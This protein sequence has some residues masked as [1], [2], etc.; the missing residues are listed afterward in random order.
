[1]TDL[2][3][4]I[5]TGGASSRMGTDKARLRLGG[6]SFVE[7]IAAA[8]SSVAAPLSVVSSRADADAAGLPVVGDV[9]AGCGALGGLHAALAHARA[10]WVAVVSCDLPFVSAEL[11]SLLAARRTRETDAVAPVQSDG[12]EQPLCA[13]YR[14][15]ACLELAE[16]LLI[17]GERRPRELLRRVRTRWLSFAEVAPLDGSACFFLNVNTPEEYEQAQRAARVTEPER[18]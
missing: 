2:E 4:F 1:M 5:L 8:L 10:E 7:R 18:A 12:R 11:F 17:E 16:R 9:H 6:R 14:R 3:G 13:L 15:D